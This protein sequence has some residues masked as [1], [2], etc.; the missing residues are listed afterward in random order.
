MM[1]ELVGGSAAFEPFFKAYVQHFS[2]APLTS[3]DFKASRAAGGR[4]GAPAPA[5][6][7]GCGALAAPC[8][9]SPRAA[10]CAA[11]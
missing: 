4:R 10:P 1:Q 9:P 7:G 2:S 11:L 6:R 8:A 5:R 3:D